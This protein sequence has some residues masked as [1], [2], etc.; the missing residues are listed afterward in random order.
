M[1][2]L[3]VLAERFRD[4]P[5]GSEKEAPPHET[6]RGFFRF[7]RGEKSAQGTT[8]AQRGARTEGD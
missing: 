6:R 1:A 5:T 8:L 3:I 4:R 7:E 2:P